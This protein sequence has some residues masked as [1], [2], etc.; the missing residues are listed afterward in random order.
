MVVPVARFEGH[1]LIKQAEAGES[2]LFFVGDDVAALES[3]RIEFSD[4]RFSDRG[5]THKI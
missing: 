2:L 4:S 5:R 1:I 3:Q